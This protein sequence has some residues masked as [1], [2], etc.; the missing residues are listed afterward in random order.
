MGGML[1]TDVKPLHCKMVLNLMDE[2]YAGSTIRQTYIAMGTMFKS[3]LMNDLIQKHP[4][5]GVKYTK[6]VPSTD[7]V[8]FLTIE[9]QQNSWKLRGGLIII[10][11]MHCFWKQDCARVR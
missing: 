3:A 9:E 10:S 7:D 8:R 5:N 4:M 2:S 6:P 1:L 11:N